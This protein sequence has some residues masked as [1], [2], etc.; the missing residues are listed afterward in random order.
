MAKIDPV[1]FNC[2]LV[3]VERC[4]HTAFTSEENA[5]GCTEQTICQARRDSFESVILFRCIF[6]SRWFVQSSTIWPKPSDVLLIRQCWLKCG[7]QAR[8]KL[9][10]IEVHGA[11]HSTQSSWFIWKLLSHRR[12]DE[13]PSTPL[14][15]SGGMRRR[16]E[17]E[18]NKCTVEASIQSPLRLGCKQ[19]NKN[20]R[21]GVAVTVEESNL[22]CTFCRQP[23][24]VL[25][26]KTACWAAASDRSV[27]T[28]HHQ[29]FYTCRSIAILQYYLCSE[30]A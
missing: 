10:T 9:V 24:T 25:R 2:L 21:Q 1:V 12:A 26:N 4:S 5:G 28:G 23:L 22:S 18:H 29:S 16:S 19:M 6:M 14:W 30:S 13:M 15:P 20:R 7:R 27:Q 17:N 11:I 3:Y 8:R